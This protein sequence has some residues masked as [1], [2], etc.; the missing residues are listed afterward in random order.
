[1][2]D[3]IKQTRMKVRD[4]K[5]NNPLKQGFFLCKYTKTQNWFWIMH[6]PN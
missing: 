2:H 1:M 5:Y 3:A 6:K 4:S